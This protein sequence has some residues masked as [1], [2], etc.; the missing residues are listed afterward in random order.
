MKLILA[1]LLVFGASLSQAVTHV[2]TL[3]QN[4]SLTFSPDELNA[5]RGDSI[6]FQFD[7]GVSFTRANYYGLRADFT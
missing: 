6:Q 2:V 7:S 5:T 1:S 3:G 4:G